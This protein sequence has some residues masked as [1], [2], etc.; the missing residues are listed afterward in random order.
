MIRPDGYI[1]AVATFDDA[2][3]VA[4]YFG[5]GAELNARCTY[6]ISDT[7]IPRDDHYPASR[8]YGCA[9]FPCQTDHARV[10]A[11]QRQLEQFE[12]AAMDFPV[13]FERAAEAITVPTISPTPTPSTARSAHNSWRNIAW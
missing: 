10:R 5:Q 3:T 7:D 6:D 2:A 1:G 9:K 4:D 11:W 13:V 8:T 12:L